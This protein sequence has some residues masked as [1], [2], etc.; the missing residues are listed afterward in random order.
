[1]DAYIEFIIAIS[2]V[3]DMADFH[4]IRLTQTTLQVLALFAETPCES[5]VAQ[6]F[7]APR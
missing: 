1:L 7:V 3:I 5:F 4:G 6:T 2:E